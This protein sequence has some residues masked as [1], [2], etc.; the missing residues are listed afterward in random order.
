MCLVLC[1]Y[2]C[3]PSLWRRKLPSQPPSKTYQSLRSKSLCVCVHSWDQLIKW[4]PFLTISPGWGTLSSLS[5]SSTLDFLKDTAIPVWCDLVLTLEGDIEDGAAFLWEIQKPADSFCL[6]AESG[7]SLICSNCALLLCMCSP[8]VLAM[9]RG[10]RSA[11]NKSGHL[12]AGHFTAATLT[13]TSSPESSLPNLPCLDT[14]T[15]A[16]YS[17]I[18]L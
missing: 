12:T 1:S 3:M 13:H 4:G 10:P 16:C 5:P 2:Y 18:A 9:P 7:N 17:E 15:V 11:N 8:F 14:K 6:K